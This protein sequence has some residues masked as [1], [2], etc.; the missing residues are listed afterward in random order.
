[1][2]PLYV[3]AIADRAPAGDLGVGLAGEAL[4]AVAIGPVAAI[5]GP[6]ESPP[7][8]S[9]AELRAH[10]AVVRRLA[11]RIPAVLPARFGSMAADGGELRAALGDRGEALAAALDRL[12][13]REQMTLREFVL[14]GGEVE[15]APPSD[16]GAGPGARYLM[17]R[18]GEA[19]G[20]AVPGLRAVLDRL[21]AVV[22]AELVERH[23]A[24]P[25]AASV[26]HLVE[27]GS[28]ARYH[29]ALGTAAAESPG[30]RL[31]ASG[32]WPPYAFAAELPDG[33]GAR[34]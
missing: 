15:P 10:D 34:G 22:A 23:H 11:A 29:H 6:M 28:A 7:R 18:A 8:P 13:G 16:P 26:Y 27:R 20:A 33:S 12:R 19:H 1:M 21:A 3:Y 4:D 32:P 9:A 2:S 31:V 14:A 25:L 24:P 5:V 17:D 30:L